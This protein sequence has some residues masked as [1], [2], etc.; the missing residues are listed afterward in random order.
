MTEIEAKA[1]ALKNKVLAERG[2]DPVTQLS[3]DEVATNEALCRAIG[4]IE[5]LEREVQKQRSL[6]D[7]YRAAWEDEKARA[8]L[9]GIE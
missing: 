7:Q 2:Y 6:R 4:E 1:L 8:A 5:R 9:G 3:R